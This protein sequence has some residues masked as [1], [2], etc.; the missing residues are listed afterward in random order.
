M[1]TKAQQ[2]K[3]A[4]ERTQHRAKKVIKPLR[5]L[6]P[7]HTDTRN[8]TRWGDKQ[9]GMALEDSMSGRPSRK[10]TRPSAHHGRADTQ[11]MRTALAKS[12]TSKARAGRAAV[13]RRK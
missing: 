8:V 6:D 7:H 11:L 9:V 12:Q 1:A 10:S 2:F 5:P 13:A 4:A 3:A